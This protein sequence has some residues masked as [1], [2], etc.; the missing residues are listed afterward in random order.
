V[1][2]EASRITLSATPATIRRGP[3]VLGEHTVEVLTD[4]LGYDE[5]R[6]GELFAAEALD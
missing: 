5:A 2:V 4:L 1:T 6:L 3:P